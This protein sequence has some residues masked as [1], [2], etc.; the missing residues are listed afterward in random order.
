MKNPLTT[1]PFEKIDYEDSNS[2]SD[3]EDKAKNV[4]NDINND[5]YAHYF[6]NDATIYMGGQNSDF[7][8]RGFSEEEKKEEKKE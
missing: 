2:D 6:T 8:L 7:S 4:K 1:E 5:D 3:K